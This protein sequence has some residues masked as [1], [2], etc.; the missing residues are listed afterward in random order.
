[1]NCTLAAGTRRSSPSLPFSEPFYYIHN[2]YTT[3]TR[4]RLVTWKI[5][6]SMTREVAQ[7]LQEARKMARS[8]ENTASSL[9]PLADGQVRELLMQIVR[10]A[11]SIAI[12]L[13]HLY[14]DIAPQ[15]FGPGSNP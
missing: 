15:A 8:I 1:M 9:E 3:H 11:Q 13:A 2:H 5:H 10:D 4:R 7:T 12:D 14:N 6:N